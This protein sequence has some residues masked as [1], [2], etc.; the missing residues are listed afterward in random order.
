MFLI[1]KFIAKEWFKALFGAVIVLFLVISIGDI[2]NGFLRNY[3]VNRIF[4][5]YFLKL[6]DLMGK[7]LPISCLLATL[8]TVNKFKN[9][10]ELMGILAGGYSANRIYKLIFSCSLVMALFQ[11]L[12]LGFVLPLANKVKRQEFEKS[13]KNESR[14]L[15]RS[16]IGDSGLVWYKTEQYFTSFEVFDPKNNLLKNISIYFISEDS[17]LNSVYQADSAVYMEDKNWK[18]SNVKIIQELEND[19]FPKY[20]NARQLLLELEETPED[21]TQFESD[22]TTLNFF[23]LGS[24]IDRLEKTDINSTEYR[25]MY[26]EKISLSLICIIFSLF[27]LSAVF[28]PNRRSA[29]FG[30]SIVITLLFSIGFWSLH[31]GFI[32]L[33]NSA[34]INPFL[35]T[36]TIILL[37][38]I[39][40]T[41]LLYKRKE[42]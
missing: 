13:R 22:I 34:K 21:F 39:Y 28:N 19:S 5:E 42:L 1:S 7:M 35:A 31:S 20:T 3:A 17:K 41:H 23:S 8:F 2:I 36:H 4:I 26:Y 40:L 30:K 25:I 33:G 16:K 38:V 10:S 12:N 11:F 32:S 9:H 18:L 6:P 24:F 37:F 27:P 29:G 15:A 14:Y